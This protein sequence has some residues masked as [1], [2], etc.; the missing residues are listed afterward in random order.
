MTNANVQ[1]LRDLTGWR[2]TG[3]S[4]DW[5]STTRALGTPLPSEF[6]E[7]VEAFAP[8][9]FQD[10]LRVLHPS[11]AGS[12]EQFRDQLL[13]QVENL[14]H[15]AEE[16]PGEVRLYPAEGGLIPWATVNSLPSVC[17]RP[18]GDDPDLWPVVVCEEFGEPWPEYHLTTAAFLAAVLTDPEAVP[19]LAHV[20]AEYQPPKFA[21]DG[22]GPDAAGTFWLAG[23]PD[24]PLAEPLFAVDA[25]AEVVDAAPI[26]G[27]DRDEYAGSI[28]SRSPADL[29]Q[30]VERLGAVRVGPARVF[31]PDTVAADIQ[32]LAGRVQA[33]RAAG[34]GPPGAMNPEPG[35]LIPWG[36]LDDGGYLCWASVPPHSNDWPVVA[37]DASLR[38]FVA[39]PMSASRFLLELATNPQGVVLPPSA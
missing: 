32:E 13:A 5:E 37:I 3:R 34:D 28:P 16:Q 7:F 33:Q 11:E 25:L 29:F 39:Y 17:W 10:W 14:R 8:G 1:R 18:V 21:A 4:I 35:G 27:F 36:R 12:P 23:L 38:H 9:E 2:G 15:D 30:V 31:S 24:G 20:A 19:D 26:P 22:A 6:R